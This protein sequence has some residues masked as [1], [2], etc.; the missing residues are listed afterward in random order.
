MFGDVTDMYIISRC[1]L[2]LNCKYDGGNNR[3]EEIIEFCRT[4]DYVTVC[5]ETAGGLESPRNPAEIVPVEDGYFKVLDKEGKDLTR[6]FDYGAELSLQSVLVEH[7]SRKRG[8]CKIEGAILK[9]NS[10]SCGSGAVYDGT[11]TGTLVGGNGLFT[12][13]LIDAYMEERNDP[14]AGPEDYVFADDF[15]ICDEKNFRR[16]FGN[17]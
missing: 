3:N 6:E 2:G 9:A 15:K 8:T 13:K 1:L 16:V 10:P 7:G 5:P 14:E 17:R 12:D 11:F 4:H